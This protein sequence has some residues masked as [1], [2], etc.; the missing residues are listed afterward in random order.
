MVMHLTRLDSVDKLNLSTR[1]HNVLR[2]ANIN[3]IGSL[4]DFPQED[5][6]TFKNM[7]AK[8]AAE[9]IAALKEI[10][11]IEIDATS[12]NS[13]NCD[14]SQA[15][16]QFMGVDGKMYYDIPVEELGLSKRPYNCVKNAGISYFSQL[17]AMSESELNDLPSMGNKSVSEILDKR[18]NIALRPVIQQQGLSSQATENNTDFGQRIIQNV[19]KKIPVNAGQLYDAILPLFSE[20]TVPERLLS[21]KLEPTLLKGIFNEPILYNA[22]KEA[23]LRKLEQSPYGIELTEL[24]EIIPDCI[25]DETQ[26]ANLIADMEQDGSLFCRREQIYERNYS[27]VLEYA[28]SLSKVQDRNVL[29]ERLAGKTLD[30]I[31]KKCNLTRERVRQIVAKCLHKAPKL[32]EDRYAAVYQKYNIGEQDLLLGF[33]VPAT[34]YNY[35]TSAYKHGDRPISELAT[36]SEVPDEFRKAAERIIYR[37]YVVLN[38]ER[39]LCHRQELSEYVLRTSGGDGVTFEEFAQLYQ[40]L[41]EDIGQQDNPKLSVMDRGYANKLA[42]SNHVLW[43]YGQKLRYYNIYSYDFTDF[44]ETLDLKQHHNVEYS[45]LKF[46]R[47]YPDLMKDYDIE[48]EYELHNLLKK[49]CSQEAFPDMHFKRMPNIEFGTA[50]RDAQVRELLL[51]LAPIANTALAEAYE[52]EYGVLTQTVLANYLQNFDQYYHAGVYKIDAPAFP[53]I[54]VSRLRQLLVDDFYLL[55]DIRKIYAE[56][57]PKADPGLLNPFTVKSLGFRVYANYA[58]SDQ[59]ASA[60]EFFRAILTKEDLVD[61]QTF[62]RE[63]LNTIAYTSEAYK[64]KASYDIVEYAPLK[65]VNIR[66]LNR[67]GIDKTILADY[68]NKVYEAAGTQYFTIHSLQQAGFSHILDELGFDEWFYASLLAEDKGRFSY[69]RMGR[70]RLFRRGNEDVCLTDF[71]EW[72]LYLR[73]SLS[74]DI[75]ELVELL[76]VGYNIS[77]DQCKIIETVK[78][79]SMYYDA[80][81]EKVYADYDVYFEEI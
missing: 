59:Y 66:R 79:S 68:C 45:T 77:I 57:F 40:M 17:Q 43:K 58:I 23:I 16:S 50:D 31:G 32:S 73:E 72:L 53:E 4:I 48:D 30:Q 36:D 18:K 81:T 54:I 13:S 41:L 28:A 12:G 6:M 21:L 27:S 46:F 80:I 19:I 69:R 47:E 15:E 39:V 5:L 62:S 60:T 35:L 75:Y 33:K 76:K 64:L 42:A 29:Q 65:Y 10:E 44:F 61:A 24:Q 38:G 20:Q 37:D 14:E 11:I 1:S 25:N 34:T 49:I 63:L 70:N 9:I 52:N 71:L 3:T 55:L 51:S 8:S 7:G 22:I 26:F 78:G 56:E 2:R 74:M 67:V